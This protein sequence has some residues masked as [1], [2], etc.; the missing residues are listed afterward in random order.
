MDS[1]AVQILAY[2]SRG[3]VCEPFDPQASAAAAV[4]VQYLRKAV[5]GVSVEHVGSTAVPGCDG[6]GILDLMAV[7]PD[8]EL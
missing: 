3:P 6:K 7:Y 1:S 5:P 2:E 8:G 4:V